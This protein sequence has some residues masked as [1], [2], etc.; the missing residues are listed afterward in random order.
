MEFETTLS[1]DSIDKLEYDGLIEQVFKLM[2]ICFQF[3]IAH[4]KLLLLSM[5]HEFK[6]TSI[7]NLVY[8]TLDIG[9]YIVNS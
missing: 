5:E 8:L 2:S 1:I 6:P 7:G 3:H 9:F 4:D